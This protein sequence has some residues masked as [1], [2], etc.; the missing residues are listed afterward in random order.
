MI[1][2]S[3]RSEL[4]S[5]LG[6]RPCSRMC[7]AVA[8]TL[9][10]AM[11]GLSSPA[12]AGAPSQA[13]ETRALAEFEAQVERA[14]LD[15]AETC[16]VSPED[17]SHLERQQQAANAG[18]LEGVASAIDD[19]KSIIDASVGWTDALP[20]RDLQT[21]VDDSLRQAKVLEAVGGLAARIGESLSAIATRF[22]LTRLADVKRV[23]AAALGRNQP[24]DVES[25]LVDEIVRQ[26]VHECR[27]SPTAPVSSS[28]VTQCV[29]FGT[30]AAGFA[31]LATRAV[32][33]GLGEIAA[34]TAGSKAGGTFLSR[35]L[36]EAWTKSLM[37][38]GE[39]LGPVGVVVELGTVILG[40]AWDLRR[41]GTHTRE[42]ARSAL[43]RFFREDCEAELGRLTPAMLDS[44]EAALDEH[45]SRIRQSVEVRLEDTWAGMLLHRRSEGFSRYVQGKPRQEWM[46]TLRRV[47]AAFGRSFTTGSIDE[48]LRLL[49]LLGDETISRVFPA[50]ADA[51]L[52]LWRQRRNSVVKIHRV[53]GL[54]TLEHI[55]GA[56]RPDTELA[57]VEATLE[58]MGLLPADSEQLP[59]DQAA[60]LI[61]ALKAVP[62]G[63][64]EEFSRALLR[65]GVP[66]L[67]DLARLRRSQTGAGAL[68]LR[69]IRDG[70]LIRSRWESIRG[71]SD[72]GLLLPLALEMP[73]GDFEKLVSRFGLDTLERF[74]IEF[75]QEG[76]R[77][78]REDGEHTLAL[79]MLPE[80]G[81]RETVLGW[82]HLRSQYGGLAGQQLSGTYGLFVWSLEHMDTRGSI[83]RAELETLRH[84]GI[85]GGWMPDLVAALIGR[86]ALYL[87][88]WLPL[89]LVAAVIFLM[90]R[91]KGL[92]ARLAILAAGPILLLLR[93]HRGRRSP[94]T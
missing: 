83:S 25:E 61:A 76:V 2:N 52:A 1:S 82:H 23:T 20:W 31:V 77:F 85:A 50:H 14:R 66:L 39:A 42:R 80:H 79:Y 5:V 13:N 47:A 34:T 63:L 65:Q 70:K 69:G 73:A 18:A 67:D 88:S 11:S 26:A 16:H 41:L 46:A 6:G 19:A 8:P 9:L 4:L 28:S 58:K 21:R 93:F 22:L 45:L 54:A 81:G 27:I 24:S 35:L 57:R 3:I 60:V 91:L 32:L 10:L 37:L 55:M 33:G 7:L 75:Q 44:L 43:D 36:G 68:L 86:S 56:N 87:G 94:S 72:A 62:E 51:F 15:L 89:G 17:R 38:P 59:R 92:L 64:P 29:P 40:A 30:L 12:L 48:K 84:A 74:L 49:H 71:R 78:L 53:A 90:F